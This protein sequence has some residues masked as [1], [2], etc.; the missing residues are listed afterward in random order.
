M[1]RYDPHSQRTI[2][3]SPPTSYSCVLMLPIPN[4]L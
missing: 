4:V 2:P 1:Y 3:Y